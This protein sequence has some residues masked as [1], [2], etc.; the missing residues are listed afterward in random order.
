M[1]FNFI[2][3]VKFC[4]YWDQLYNS[5]LK[6]LAFHAFYPVQSTERH[7]NGQREQVLDHFLKSLHQ[8]VLI[9]LNLL[10][11]KAQQNPHGNAEHQPLHLW[12]DQHAGVTC[13]PFLHCSLNFLLDNGDIEL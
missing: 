9:G 5:T 10:W 12:V 6:I 8:L 11:L 7:I 4:Y 2:L 3:S 1:Y 13:Q